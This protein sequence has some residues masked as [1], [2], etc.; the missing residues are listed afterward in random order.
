LA[1]DDSKA[2]VRPSIRPMELDDLPQVLEI[3]RRSFPTPWS[4]K[5]FRG[6]LTVNAYAYYIVAET[7]GRVVGYA[8][9]WVIMDE[10]HVTNIAVHPDYRR[11]GVGRRL[12]E[13]LIERAAD[14]G[15]DRMTL[16]VRKSN[17]AAQ[18]LYLSFDFVP[19][20]IRR[21]YYTDT[22]EDAI[23]MWKYRLQRW[24]RERGGRDRRDAVPG[25]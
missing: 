1:P 17:H 5:A 20:G 25:P 3:E 7:D 18:Q 21:G 8:G 14:R 4:E 13:A 9:M 15:C 22:N 23:V 2:P 12:L 24:R 6:E 16:E 19:R 10:A 11:S